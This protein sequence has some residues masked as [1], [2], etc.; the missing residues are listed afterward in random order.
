A[1]KLPK[2]ALV[3]CMRKLLTILNAMVRSNT[4]WDDSLHKA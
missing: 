4:P 1:G 3:A 2:V